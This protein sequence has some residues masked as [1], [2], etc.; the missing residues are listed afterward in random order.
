MTFNI[1][2][3]KAI[4][5][6]HDGL[7]RS[8]KFELFIT[9]PFRNAMA[10]D[11]R[12]FAETASI[13]GIGFT[14]NDIKHL[15]YGLSSANPQQTNFE[16]MTVTFLADGA[17][18]VRRFFEQWVGSIYNHGNNRFESP[19]GLPLYRYAFPEEY[20]G[21]IVIRM[22]NDTGRE[23]RSYSLLRAYPKAIGATQVGWEMNDVVNRIP[24]TFFFYSWKSDNIGFNGERTGSD[25][26]FND[27]IR[28]STRTI[29]NSIQT[30]P[31]RSPGRD[32]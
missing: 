6:R 31:M 18:N 17:G 26:A 8:A 3:F 27:F 15:G 9:P 29:T 4:V 30:Q 32:R 22:F 23:S 25:D 20:E 10:G 11:L 21:T 7:Q 2:T 5:N 14:T 13:P 19:S 28:S 16:D 12:F 1:E 24:V